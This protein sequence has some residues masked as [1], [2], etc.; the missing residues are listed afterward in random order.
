MAIILLL[1]FY[2]VSVS[3]AAPA[4]SQCSDR[5]DHDG[6]GYCDY[7][8]NARCSDNS[9]PGDSGCSNKF[10][11]SEC[12]ISTE[13]CDGKDNDC[14]GTTD[15]NCNADSCT[16]TDSGYDIGIQGTVSGY[17]L[18]QPYSK[19]D[20][21]LNSTSLLEYFCLSGATGTKALNATVVC[22][23]S[24]TTCINGACAPL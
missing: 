8:A 18:N 1:G 12:A 13:I 6:D 11:N 23:T 20:S 22:P 17:N 19:T 15:E 16:D 5:I 10:D 7:G 24:N 14:D 4:K 9:I 2:F 3:V 21:C